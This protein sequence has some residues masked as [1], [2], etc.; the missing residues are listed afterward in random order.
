MK[1][2]RSMRPRTALAVRP[3]RSRAR[4]RSRSSTRNVVAAR[5]E[6]MLRFKLRLVMSATAPSVDGMISMSQFPEHQYTTRGLSLLCETCRYEHP[7][8]ERLINE[9]VAII[10]GSP[11]AKTK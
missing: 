9:L 7:L 6:H 2:Y 4:A 11:A 3:G 8:N 10:I 1:V 5:S